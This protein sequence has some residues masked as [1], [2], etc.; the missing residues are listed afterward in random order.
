MQLG[1]DVTEH[2][3]QVFG[4]FGCDEVCSWPVSFG[5]RREGWMKNEEEFAKYLLNSIV[6]FFSNAK[7]KSGNQVLLKVDSG[8]GRM[9]L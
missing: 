2:V 3:P 1:D 4:E 6:A 9:N 8:L 7:D 5:T